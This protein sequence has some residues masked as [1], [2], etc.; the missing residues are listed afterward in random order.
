LPDLS[1]VDGY[2]TVLTV[3]AILCYVLYRNF[4]RRGGL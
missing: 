4:K 1:S 3:I 2:P